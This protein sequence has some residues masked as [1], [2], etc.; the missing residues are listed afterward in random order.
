MTSPARAPLIL[1]VD[2]D[3]ST[4]QMIQTILTRSGFQTACAFDVSGAL[5]QIRERHPD[6]ILLDVSL[7]DGSGFEVCRCLQAESGT[8]QVPVLFISSND[9]V[10]TKVQGFE[11]GGVDYITKP[12]AGAEVIARITTHLRLRQ[13][14]ETLAGLQAERIQRLAGVQEAI[15]PL[16]GDLPEARFAVF[17]K[18]IFKAGGD[19]YDVVPIGDSVVDYMVADVSGH[20]LAA[21]FW[22]AALKTLF[23]AYAAPINSP[24]DVMQS[25]NRVLCRIVPQGIFF[26]ALYARLN[27]QSGRLSL[28]NAGHPPAIT[29]P[30]DG[31]E[32][33]VVRQEGDVVGSF[34]D[35]T[36][37]AVEL[38]VRPGDRF[39][40]YS[41]GLIEI[42]GN[43]EEG[44][45]RLA[46]ACS[47]LREA[48]LEN[49]VPSVVGEVTS[50]ATAQDD[51]LL[52]GVEV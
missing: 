51:L 50:R 8:S 45:R 9:D 29:V 27:R 5:T 6:L 40:L 28:A 23:S 19:F 15:M 7:P 32:P 47:A 52:L 10:S 2:D 24:R 26:T 38:S 20:D 11:S 43:R 36:Y 34:P 48:A 41:D 12:I 4:N 35:A 16:A 22:T 21:S 42:G 13:A 44:I 49:M 18:Q 37:G 3:V 1:I 17:L 14:Y 31:N 39:L 25:M 30:G 33:V 46:G